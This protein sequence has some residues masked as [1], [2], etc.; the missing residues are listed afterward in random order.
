MAK[1]VIV[2]DE[3]ALA[4]LYAEFLAA[5]GYE[6][7]TFTNGTE[8]LAYALA[9]DWQYMFLDIMLPGLDGVEVLRKLKTQQ[10]LAGRTVVMLTNLETEAIIK[11]CLSLGATKYLNK[12]NINPQ[13]LLTVIE[14]EADVST[15]TV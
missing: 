1:I 3:L 7:K 12:A 10:M 8:A 4:E 5:A 14:G 13:A 2:E 15:N 6:V 11:E 9:G